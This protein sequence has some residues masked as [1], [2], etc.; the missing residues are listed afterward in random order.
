MGLGTVLPALSVQL[1]MGWDAQQC[2]F[3]VWDIETIR[4]A[5]SVQKQSL[6]PRQK[7]ELFPSVVNQLLT[8]C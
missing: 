6:F 1:I 2:E 5:E 4:P 8:S 3:N 7:E